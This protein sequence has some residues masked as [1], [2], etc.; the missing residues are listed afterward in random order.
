MVPSVKAPEEALSLDGMARERL[1][2]RAMA[3]IRKHFTNDEMCHK[4]LAVYAEVMNS[5]DGGKGT[6]SP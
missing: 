3:H 4:T 2:Q 6:A 1:A 5:G